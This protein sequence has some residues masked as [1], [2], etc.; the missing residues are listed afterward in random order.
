VNVFNF[1]KIKIF[2]VFVYFFQRFYFKVLNIQ[3]GNCGNL[4]HLYTKIEKS[5]CCDEIIV[6]FIFRYTYV[7]YCNTTM[8][9]MSV[10]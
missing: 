6:Y 1:K 10:I 9:L 7:D 8:Q 2:N 3:C 5:K 4:K